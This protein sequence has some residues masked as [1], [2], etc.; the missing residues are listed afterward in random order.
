VSVSATPPTTVAEIVALATK[1]DVTGRVSYQVR[2]HG[3][4]FVVV[5]AARARHGLPTVYREDVV[6]KGVR[7]IRG[8][9]GAATTFSCVGSA[10]PWRC[11]AGDPGQRVAN[12][13]GRLTGFLSPE[14][15]RMIFGSRQLTAPVIT[16][17][18]ESGQPVSCLGGTYK[19]RHVQL[20]VAAWG[21]PLSMVLGSDVRVVATSA[22]STV[23]PQ[24]LGR[25]Y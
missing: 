12:V 1:R 23:R 4:K 13:L 22:S 25:P 10:L 11:S 8:T 17:R 24:E 16:Q 9:R 6:F 3:D 18:V 15:V 5:V 20:C 2:G 7:Y 21:F 19:L 14:T